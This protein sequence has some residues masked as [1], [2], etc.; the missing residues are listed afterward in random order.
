MFLKL[1]IEACYEKLADNIEDDFNVEDLV[2][3][4]I[5]Y[6][7][8]IKEINDILLPQ[9]NKKILEQRLGLN[10]DEPLTF[11]QIAEKSNLSRE[12]IRQITMGILFQM[13]K[14]AVYQWRN[15]G[16]DMDETK[17]MFNNIKKVTI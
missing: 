11:I 2:I 9:K 8:I 13:R 10:G 4:S 12:R 17:V 16:L 7:I 5:N 3:D 6:P 1:I 15:R 14:Y